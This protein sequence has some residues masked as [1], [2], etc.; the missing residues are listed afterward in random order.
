MTDNND[1]SIELSV[2]TPTYN[3][4]LCV[5]ETVERLVRII[6]GLG[7]S[8]ELI[9]IN[10]GSIDNTGEMLSHAAS[11][12]ENIRVVSY[13][14]NRGRGYALRRGI[15][16]SRGT[17]II[18]VEF[19][20]NYGE[21]IISQLYNELLTSEAD[22]VIASPYARGGKV[23]NVPVTRALLSRWGNRIL[24]RTISASVT[25]LTG[26]TRGYRGNTIRTLPLNNDGKEVNL[27]ILSKAIML[28]MRITEVPATLRWALKTNKKPTRKSKSKSG[29]LILSHL[30]FASNEAPIFLFG[31][32]GGIILA[33]G[34]ILGLYLAYLYFVCGQLIGERIVLILT[35]TF[36]V[37]SGLSIF[38]FCFL[39]YQIRHLQRE[40]LRSQY[41]GSQNS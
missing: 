24:A 4:E 3:E 38:L 8:W 7:V 9:V 26:M 34:V 28:G 21:D 1:H 2:I 16:I 5:Q 27:E 19:D 10:D 12:V 20:L 23:E 40:L 18:T 6:S 30:L 14:E 41:R 37:I 32:I 33:A 22:I 25:T 31:T 36:L 13:R 39:S 29:K 15:N 17:F 11:T 35:T